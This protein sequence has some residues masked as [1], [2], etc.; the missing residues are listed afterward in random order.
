MEKL[1][2]FSK[3]KTLFKAFVESQF[4]YCPIAWMFHSRRTNIKIYRLHERPLRTVYDDDRL[5]FDQLL[6]IE[7]SF[8]IPI[9]QSRDS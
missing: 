3:R 8:C 9:K 1:L 6:S 2:T 5:I 7:E 4:E